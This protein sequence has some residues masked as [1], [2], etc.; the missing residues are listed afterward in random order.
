MLTL[1]D[2]YRPMYQTRK[3][4]S[5][6]LLMFLAA[7]SLRAQPVFLS[8]E[9]VTSPVERFGLFEL[10]VQ[11]QTNTSKFYDYDSIAL[12]A[13]FTAPSGIESNIDGFYYQ[14]FNSLENGLLEPDGSPYWKI[15]FSP[16]ETG[17]YS[18]YL[19][20]QDADGLAQ[21]ETATFAVLE[22]DRNGFVAIE[23]G[24]LMLRNEQ[25]E[26]VFLIGENIA[27]ANQQD[28]SDKMHYYLGRLA[29]H[30]GNFAKLMMTPWGYQIE[31]IEGGLRNYHPR[32]NQAFLLDSIFR[33]ANQLG[34][35][36]Q[37]AFSIHNELNFG[38]PAEDWTSNPYN[39]I[40]GG[41]CVDPHEF[42]T[43]VQAREAFRNKIRYVLAR[44][45]YAE[46]LVA[47]ELLSEADNFPFYQQYKAEIVAWA[48]DLAQW[49]NQHDPF[50][51]LVSVGFALP[52]SEND[53]WQDDQILFTQMHLYGKDSDL[54]GH[55]FRQIQHYRE[56][57][58]KPV[59]V[60]EWGL[61]H[62][63]DSMPIW[64]PQGIAFHN[65]MWTSALTASMGTIVPWYWE[66]YIDQLDLYPVFGAVHN[67][68]NGEILHQVD[69][70]PV[71]LM[72]DGEERTDFKIEPKYFSL[73]QAS[74]ST[75]FDV[76]TTGQ[77]KPSADSLTQFLYGPLSVFSGL[78][79]EVRL[80]A[81]FHHPSLVTI[82]TGAQVNSS[83]LQIT[84][85]GG[86]VFEQT[87][88]AQQ[89][90]TI[91]VQAGFHAIGLANT[92]LSLT[93]AMELE[94]ISFHDFLPALRAFGLQMTDRI[95]G[96]IHNRSYHWKHFYEQSAP[97]PLASG[98]IIL[99]L[100]QG[101]HEIAWYNTESGLV[102]SISIQSC[103]P[104]GL[105]LQLADLQHDIA[106]KT[107]QLVGFREEKQAPSLLVYPNPSRNDFTF[108]LNMTRPGNTLLEVFDL[109]G[110]LIDTVQKYFEQ[111]G[112][113]KV[114][115]KASDLQNLQH[116]LLIYRFTMPDQI[117]TGKLVL[118]QP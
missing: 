62:F 100:T 105:H 61:G 94:N 45:G 38:Y 55:V 113:H 29:E 93:S 98:S 66:R 26:T 68:L 36:L 78:R 11:I 116:G 48:V 65:S 20:V 56:K 8:V 85:D 84:V 59:L 50:Q 42:F 89:T 24:S 80:H 81:D 102:D 69:P 63:S 34:V 71:H 3:P 16:R 109:Q 39:L 4:V 14:H 30:K 76:Y 54:E 73:T 18:Y 90:V 111:P 104:D 2:T 95:F 40:N 28:G 23:E 57:F 70:L 10:A 88:S 114:K 107:R 108:G 49:I 64:D 67:F 44:W 101:E 72:S 33:Y 5:F 27:W 52:E 110:R 1:F 46:N 22:S 9:Q 79:K 37:L 15:R 106:F 41:Y 17:I 12:M 112:I 86:V 92:G 7:F 118:K 91:E 82:E 21:S 74:P 32:Q 83:V 87:V 31:W 19:K 115:W 25:D 35:F 75:I 99:P 6:L 97:P 60:G 77:M 117:I 13:V 96:W 103:Q 53:L 51:H 43:N 47:W 58:N